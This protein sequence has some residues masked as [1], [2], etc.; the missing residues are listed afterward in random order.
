[1]SAQL[2]D[3][4]SDLIDLALGDLEKCEAAPDRFKVNMGEWCRQ[5]S[6]DRRCE[7]CL[8]GSVLT[9]TLG[10]TFDRAEDLEA[11][12]A[13]DGGVVAT[14]EDFDERTEAKL[15]ALDSLRCGNVSEAVDAL[16]ELGLGLRVPES[17]KNE[18]GRWERF[19]PLYDDKDEYGFKAAMRE[20]AADLRTEGL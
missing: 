7:V 5:K 12:D 19:M 9:Q 4:P 11:F 14:P 1:M 10:F 3:K 15:L 13:S 18:R 8:A 20:L 17:C 2:P 6:G 16:N